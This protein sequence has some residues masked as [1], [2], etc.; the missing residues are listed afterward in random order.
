MINRNADKKYILA[1]YRKFDVVRLYKKIDEINKRK[2]AKGLSNA[3]KIKS[4]SFS[5]CRIPKNQN[6]YRDY[7]IK[8][9]N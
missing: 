2:T 8:Q 4:D 9:E 7:D 1:E 6:E 5:L 3:F